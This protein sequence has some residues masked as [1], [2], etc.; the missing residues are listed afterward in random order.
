MEMSKESESRLGSDESIVVCAIAGFCPIAVFPSGCFYLMRTFCHSGCIRFG[1]GQ[2][3]LFIQAGEAAPARWRTS[4]AQ[5]ITTR[6]FT[7]SRA[8]SSLPLYIS[9]LLSDKDNAYHK[10]GAGNILMIVTALL[11]SL[12]VFKDIG[13]SA[14]CFRQ[15]VGA[16]EFFILPTLHLRPR[17]NFNPCIDHRKPTLSAFRKRVLFLVWDELA[18]PWAIFKTQ[19]LQGQLF[20][21]LQ[22]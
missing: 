16:I 7:P 20:T 6:T 11:V 5:A 13:V 4:S 17:D 21:F 18:L 2:D 3:R 9:H 1:A 10:Q 14:I 15:R 19:D 12:F 8:W 22:H